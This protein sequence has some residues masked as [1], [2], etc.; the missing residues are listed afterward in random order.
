MR[1]PAIATEDG[2]IV[3]AAIAIARAFDLRVTAEGIETESQLA[4]LRRLECDL[5][6]GYLFSR[7]LGADLIAPRVLAPTA[8]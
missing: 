7:P 8:E 1:A 2:V 3:S 5:G 4:E 6:Q